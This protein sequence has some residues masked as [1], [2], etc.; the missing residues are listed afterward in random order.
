MKIKAYA[1]INILLDIVGIKENGYHLLEMIMQS[2]DLYDVIDINKIEKGIKIKCNKSYIP[3]NNKNIAYKAAELFMK[4]YGINEG[5][6]INI[7]KNIPTSA[8]LGG[9]SADGAA[10]LKAMRKIFNVDIS[11]KELE[12]L[13]VKIGADVPFCVSGGTALCEGIGEIIT[14]MSKFQNK[15]LVVVKPKFGV[16]TKWVYSEYDNLNSVKKPETEK[17]LNAVKNDDLKL[18][19][20]KMANVL[21]EVTINKYGIIDGIKKDMLKFGALGAMMSGSGPSVFAFFEDSLSAQRCFEKMK[22]NYPETFITRT[23]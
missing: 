4:T 14:P 3:V 13:G 23:I 9:G 1:K 20:S 12:E 5:V 15:I 21:E 6:S 18:V 16:S 8:G 22:E 2:I 11:N 10:V 19:S 17:I 7:Y